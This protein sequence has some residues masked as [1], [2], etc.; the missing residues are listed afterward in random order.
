[1][2][3]PLKKFVTHGYKDKI[4]MIFATVWATQHHLR[5]NHSYSA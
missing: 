1:M 5:L 3:P 2:W 4:H